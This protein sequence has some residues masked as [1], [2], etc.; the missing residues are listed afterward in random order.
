MQECVVDNR[1]IIRFLSNVDGGAFLQKK[2][3]AFS[4]KPL[5][6]CAKQLSQSC[7]TEF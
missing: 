5:A 6:I 3:T 1:G 4:H 7:L 2:L